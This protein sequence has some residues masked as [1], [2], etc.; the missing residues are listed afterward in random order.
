M[1][2]LVDWFAE[3]DP[4]EPVWTWSPDKSVGFWRRMQTI[5]AAI[6]RW[7][8]QNAVGTALRSMP[9]WPATQ[10]GRRSRSWCRSGAPCGRLRRVGASGSASERPTVPV[11]G[12]S[13]ST[14]TNCASTTNSV[15]A[16]SSSWVRRPISCCFSGAASLPIGSPTYAA[17]ATP[18]DATSRSSRR[19]VTR[20]GATVSAQSARLTSRIDDA[21]MATRTCSATSC[22]T[23]ESTAIAT[24]AW[25]PL[26]SRLTCMP[27]M[28]TWA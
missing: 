10:F 7:D 8:A 20:P 3:R 4:T 27:A 21:S 16:M 2:G 9:S 26:R 6:H 24:S 5:G 13:T 25:P 18:P 15:R 1:S 19:C 28:L 14:V 12:R 22:G 17:I 23:G 11:S